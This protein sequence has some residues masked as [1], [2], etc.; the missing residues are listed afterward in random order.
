LVIE[1]LQPS[2]WAGSANLSLLQIV[3]QHGRGAAGKLIKQGF[4]FRGAWVGAGE[5]TVI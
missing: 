2:K 4:I 1:D 3:A 5:E